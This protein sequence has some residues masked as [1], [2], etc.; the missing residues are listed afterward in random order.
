[1]V[2][3]ASTPAM[4]RRLGVIRPNLVQAPI[5]EAERKNVGH[6]HDPY[7]PCSAAALPLIISSCT[8]SLHLDVR[9]CYNSNHASSEPTFREH[10]VYFLT[11]RARFVFFSL[12]L[13][14]GACRAEAYIIWLIKQTFA[15]ALLA[16][17]HPL[18]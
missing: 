13:R 15:T 3:Y 12:G 8:E 18:Y 1:V 7:G 16:I 14:L 4:A 5:S 10:V 9:F 11:V 2:S 6:M 17:S